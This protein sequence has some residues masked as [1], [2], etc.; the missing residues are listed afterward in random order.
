MPFLRLD[1]MTVSAVSWL[2]PGWLPRGKMVILD[3]NP[4][5]GKSL[6][7]LDLCARVTTG[8]AV[9]A[10]GEAGEP[11]N[12]VLLDAEDSG[13][14]VVLP[15]LK[16]LGADLAR[17]YY[18]HQQEDHLPRIPSQIRVL[19]DIVR[20]TEA[21]LLVVD[22][23]VAFLDTS[24]QVG[25]DLSIRQALQPLGKVSQER[26]SCTVMNR[27]LNKDTR[28]QAMYRGGGSI[29][30]HGACRVSW[31]AAADPLDPGRRVLAQ[32]K[33][34]Y[35]PLQPS[36]GYRLE[37]RDDEMPVL[38]WLERVPWAA[39]QLAA[40]K[41]LFEP[42]DLA[43]EFLLTFLEAGARPRREV[44]DAAATHQ[45]AERTVERAK[46]ELK[47]QSQPG[48]L[49]GKYAMYWRLPE[50]EL[51]TTSATENLPEVEEWLRPFR[52]CSAATRMEEAG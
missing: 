45:L 18:F 4:G 48:K 26:G 30:F 47:I 13:A 10:D 38:H 31:L 49:A 51:A 36:V 2:V 46:T 25:S 39:D 52:E 14:D 23:I 50:Q 5:M 37:T 22:P 34:N 42:V 28:L 11:G 43:K 12:V 9:F 40:S 32:V 35:A 41:R 27:H 7:T 3:G 16:A 6:I 15:R 21:R 20:K 24:I 8:R 44:L 33:N 29:G 19:D 17:V 1:E